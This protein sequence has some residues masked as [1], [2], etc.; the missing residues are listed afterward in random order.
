MNDGGKVREVIYVLVLAGLLVWCVLFMNPHRVGVVDMDRVF[1][2][3]GMIQKIEKEEQRRGFNAK[4]STLV[5][6]YN[7][8][9]KALKSKMDSATTQV[10]K[11]KIITQ[12]K[13]T[14]EQLQQNIQPL[15]NQKQQFE[16]AAVATFKKRLQPFISQVG[17]KRG[18]DIVTFAGSNV[19]YVR[20]EA[21][22]TEA[23]VNA[24]KEY[25]AKDMPLIMDAPVKK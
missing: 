17:Q 7:A 18:V 13:A 23:V 10:E 12:L 24:A 25:F 6:A 4:A 9:I 20:N 5:Q 8:R 14:D 21:D 1:K 3:T 11:D 15:R 22:L 2:D 19:P 16:S